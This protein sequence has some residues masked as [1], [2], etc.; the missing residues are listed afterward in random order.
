VQPLPKKHL[1]LQVI[2]KVT[3]YSIS[4]VSRALRNHPR[5]P[6]E[7][8]LKIQ[9]VATEA[10]YTPDAKLRELMVHVRKRTTLVEAPVLA[11]IVDVPLPL[12]SGWEDQESGKG[13]LY[14]A[15]QHAESLGY[16]FE[17]FSL[18][19]PG[20]TPERLS[21]ILYH[22]GVSGILVGSMQDPSTR[23]RMDWGRFSSVAIGHSVAWPKLNC[24]SN[25]QFHSMRTCYKNTQA[26]GYR[27]LGLV[28]RPR[29]DARVDQNLKASFMVEQL[30]EPLENRVPILIIDPDRQDV[31]QDWYQAHRCDAVIYGGTALPI[32]HWLEELGYRIPRDIGII[33][34][35]LA[36]HSG[37]ETGMIQNMHEVA[38]AAVDLLVSQMQNNRRGIPTNPHYLLLEGSWLEGKTTRRKTQKPKAPRKASA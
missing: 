30:A 10:G 33:N 25:H 28:L 16:K 14:A 27:K 2:A 6:E 8:C 4:T 11:C 12:F 1:S 36:D 18:R 17:M 22:R 29:I 5:I 31:F 23:L 35:G 21:D 15:K 24:A 34:V 38:A 13:Y 37:R 20:I 26:L 7:T 19:A 3:G 32:R 9:K